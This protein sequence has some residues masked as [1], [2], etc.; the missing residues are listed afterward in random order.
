MGKETSLVKS[1]SVNAEENASKLKR[2]HYPKSPTDK[3]IFH[4]SLSTLNIDDTREFYES[5]FGC[6]VRRIT[7]SKKG[8]HI[9]FFGHQ[10]TFVE[11][12]PSKHR[13]ISETNE[14]G[15]P[16]VH[17]GVALPYYQWFAIKERL[18][19][20]QVDFCVQPHLK[21]KGEPHEHYVMFAKDPSG[22]ALEIK[23]FTNTSDWL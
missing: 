14:H 7:K 10:L 11:V 23:S 5:N 21:F 16:L 8:M 3:K 4:L 20:N 17:F 15:S 9:D 1:L 6:K 18:I 2:Q 19:G 13:Q 22:N 12:P